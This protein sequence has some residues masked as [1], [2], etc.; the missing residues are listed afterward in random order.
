MANKRTEQYDDITDVFANHPEIKF[1]NHGYYPIDHRF[2][3]HD[4]GPSATL[5]SLFL[6]RATSNT[7]ILDIGCGRGGGSEIAKHYYNFSEIH[8]CDLHQGNLSFCKQN[9]SGVEFKISDAESLAEYDRD[10]F[11]YAIN[12]ESS[13]CYTSLENFYSSV[14]R[15]LRPSGTFFYAD[16]FSKIDS[17]DSR[18]DSFFV[19]KDKIDLTKNVVYSCRHYVNKLSTSNKFIDR[20]HAFLYNLFKEKAELYQSRKGLFIGYV[21][22][23]NS[24]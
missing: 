23:K 2:A 12:I 21:L 7:K 16:I 18:L 13:H 22:E 15:I 9:I 24:V 5:Y 10:Y 1:M 4:Q 3:K 20:A 17:A 11:D 14:R 8:A 19:I 6:D